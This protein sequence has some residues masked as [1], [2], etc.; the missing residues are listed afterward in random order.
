M[1]IR[2]SAVVLEPESRVLLI[3]KL[4]EKLQPLLEQGWQMKNRPPAP[5]EKLPHHMTMTMGSL[6]IAMKDLVGSSQQLIA[7]KWGQSDKA[8]AVQVETSVPSNNDV[9]HITVAISPTGKPFHSNE[10][11]EWVDIDPIPLIG[12][13]EEVA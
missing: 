3:E 6:P 8:A 11:T 5:E 9:K 12:K 10:I 13:I 2:Y 4:Q 7:V 1:R